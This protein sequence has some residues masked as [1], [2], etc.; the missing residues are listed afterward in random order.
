MPKNRAS[1]GAVWVSLVVFTG[2]ASVS[3]LARPDVGQRT[4]QIKRI[5]IF[6][7]HLRVYEI[8]LSGTRE[9]IQGWSEEATRNFA[10]A[11]VA[12]GEKRRAAVFRT[13]SIEAM[14]DSQRSELLDAQALLSAINLNV[15]RHVYGSKPDLFADIIENFDLSLGTDTSM[16]DVRDADAFVM[17]NGVDHVSSSGRV[18]GEIIRWSASGPLGVILGTPR[19]GQTW[20]SLALVDARTGDILWYRVERSFGGYNVRDPEDVKEIMRK[21]LMGFPVP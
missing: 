16:F 15:L 12:A 4:P 2:C 14:S 7:P 5:V 13:V 9:M 3:Y 17:V 1:W 8:K 21:L 18:A 11:L 6:P 20:V 10:S 19:F